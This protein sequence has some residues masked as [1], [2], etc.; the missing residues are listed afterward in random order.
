VQRNP[1]ARS[2]GGVH[3]F[4]GGNFD[5]KQDESFA[6]TAIRETFEE[7]GLLIASSADLSGVL[8]DDSVL[9]EARQAIHSRRTSF[10]SF[11]AQYRLKADVASL[12]RFTEWITPPK[13][14]PRRFHTRFYLVFLRGASSSGF[15]SGGKQDRIP[16][17]DG[18]Q[19]VIAARFL[20]PDDALAEYREGKIALMPPQYYILH[21]LSPILRGRE[22]TEAQRTGIE[23][24]SRGMFGRMVMTPRRLGEPDEQGR[25][26]LTYPGDHAR[27]GP[28]G[29]LHRSVLK[30]GKQGVPSD[31]VLHRNFDIFTEI[32]A[33]TSSPSFKL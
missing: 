29:R 26:T 28:K 16:K 31:I 11:L 25:I 5:E 21:T 1:Q 19:E 15:S 23:Q 17:P 30:F 4:P 32:E 2:F 8:P 33:D 10:Q 12:L 3:V 18:G 6:M 20:H 24:L 13:S 22:N 7:S 9:D 14:Q 27:G